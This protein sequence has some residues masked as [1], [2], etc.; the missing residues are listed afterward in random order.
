MNSAESLDAQPAQQNAVALKLPI[1]WA[2]QLQV[3]FIHIEAQ[4]ELRNIVA[5][6]T[7]F[8]NVVVALSQ[9]T[10]TRL[11]PNLQNPPAFGKYEG[12]SRRDHAA[13]LLHM[14]GL[15]DRKPSALMSEILEF[16]TAFS[17]WQPS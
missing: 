14:V 6:A 2:V 12:L 10:A 17:M 4:F 1:F 7:R 16:T 13:R 11:L 8:F 9:E 3:W 15:G 5:V